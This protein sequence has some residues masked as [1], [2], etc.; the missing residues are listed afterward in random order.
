MNMQRMETESGIPASPVSR[1]GSAGGP[2]P[3]P[4]RM[5]IRSDGPPASGHPP[6]S[7]P[8][9]GLMV[10]L[11][12][13]A[14]TASAADPD[15][16]LE[17]LE[18][19]EW[20]SWLSAAEKRTQA[21]G[22]RDLEAARHL[23]EVCLVAGDSETA[24]TAAGMLVRI[25]LHENAPGP[26]AKAAVSLLMYIAGKNPAPEVLERIESLRAAFSAKKKAL[27]REATEAEE[28][29]RLDE[30]ETAWREA[31]GLPFAV[32]G[33]VGQ[34]LTEDGLLQRLSSVNERIEA[35]ILSRSTAASHLCPACEGKS[36]HVCPTCD[37][38]GWIR[39]IVS[40]PGGSA[41]GK[42]VK[43]KCSRCKGLGIVMCETCKWT[44]L[45]LGLLPP[46]EATRLAKY[47]KYAATLLRKRRLDEAVKL[48]QQTALE[49]RL[50]LP[51][52]FHPDDPQAAH[53]FPYR[54]EKNWPRTFVDTWNARG[55]DAVL[56]RY[57]L[58]LDFAVV[59]SKT[60]RPYRLLI[61]LENTSRPVRRLDEAVKATVPLSPDR[62]SA[63]P[64]F[65]HDR[66]VSMRGTFTGPED[67]EGFRVLTFLGIPGPNTD[68]VV[69]YVWGERG[70]A[71]A[72]LSAE[73]HGCFRPLA[74][75][76]YAYP[77]E[78]ANAWAGSLSAGENVEV[79]GRFL[80][81]KDKRPRK[82]FEIWRGGPGAPPPPGETDESPAPSPSWNEPLFSRQ[83]AWTLTRSSPEDLLAG[84][85]GYLRKALD[86]AARVSGAP[87]DIERRNR[88]AVRLLQKAR[89]FYEKVWRREG[90]PPAVAYLIDRVNALLVEKI[91]SARA[92]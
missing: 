46:D 11:A 90:E 16:E 73:F 82:L 92:G 53:L 44:G 45:N 79:F 58:L 86:I 40:D 77:F 24:S 81:R 37:G 17:A 83:E 5:T 61:G 66:W 29:G 70:K 49:L 39:K 21:G 71:G 55:G 74:K 75:F 60:M 32:A 69:S 72:R 89:A 62:L 43:V 33:K 20:S 9:V 41:S 50:D 30:A 22:R 76:A 8:W 19:G 34:R 48:A 63:F 38:K 4:A 36:A 35:R 52:T 13:F 57:N 25:H 14:S 15:K 51:D 2:E 26:G 18:P 65:Y 80:F 12:S 10:L 84:G 54:R 23:L 91:E 56:D 28:A 6:L 88:E 64:A 47:A 68:D 42:R 7:I 87:G 27:V 67:I 85:N 59:A 3:R 78:E 31:L 1:G